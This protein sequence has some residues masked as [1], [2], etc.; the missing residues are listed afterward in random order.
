MLIFILGLVQTA[1]N[2]EEIYVREGCGKCHSFKGHGG[3]LAPDLT[4]VVQ[5]QVKD[6]GS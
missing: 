4:S 6:Y 2:G 1:S 3:A 5:R